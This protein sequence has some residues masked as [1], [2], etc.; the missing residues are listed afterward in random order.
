M[1]GHSKWSTIKHKKAAADAKRGKIFTRL[2]KEITVAARAGGSDTSSN[3]R[4]R[5]AVDKARGANMPKDNIER[6]IKRGTGELD[7][8]ELEEAMYEAYA[9]HGIGV[10]VEIVTDNRNRAVAEVRH[11]LNKYGGAMAEAG[12]VAWQFT[13]KGYIE[14]E[15]DFDQDD[16]FLVAADAGADDVRFEDGLAEVYAGLDNLQS[17]RQALEDAGYKLSEVSVFFDANNPVE[18]E[19]Q[20]AKQIV[21]LVEVLEELDDVQD[22]YTTLDYDEEALAALEV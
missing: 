1:S 12:A 6:A 5:L 20:Q 22:V 21:N 11:V 18:L 10:I 8:G 14:V 9:P 16:L 13:R 7:G 3:V 17:V 15:S 19:P 4:L 2:A